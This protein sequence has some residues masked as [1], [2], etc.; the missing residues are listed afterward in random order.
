MAAE[1]SRAQA[2]FIIACGDADSRF[3]CHAESVF[4]EQAPFDFECRVTYSF[5]IIDRR[6]IYFRV[7]PEIRQ[8]QDQ[9]NIIGD[10]IG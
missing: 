6:F 10:P 5:F 9:I 8:V 2:F 7:S 4:L 3:Q 1:L